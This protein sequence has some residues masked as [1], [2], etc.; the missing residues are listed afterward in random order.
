MKRRSFLSSLLSIAALCVAPTAAR[1]TD[2]SITAGSVVASAAA[3]QTNVIRGTAGASLTAG[4]L[5]YLDAATQTF[6]LADADASAATAQVIGMALHAA[7]SGQPIAVLTAD[8]NLT[9]GATLSM[10]APVYVLSATAGGIAPVA[11]LT[12]GWRPAPVLVAISTTKAIFR[13]SA[14]RG[15]AAAVAP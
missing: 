13:A 4:Q 6:K 10:S 5:L 9:V 7:A 14:L 1:A 8:D 3:L 2:L 15:T 11:D 12:T